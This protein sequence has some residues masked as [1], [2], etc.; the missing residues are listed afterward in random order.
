MGDW[1]TMVLTAASMVVGERAKSPTVSSS[2]A[3]DNT[4][5]TETASRE[6]LTPYVPHTPAGCRMEPPVS[7][8][9][10]KSSQA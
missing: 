2:G 8:P 1:T 7:V 4:P 9:T 3:T 10:V 6:G 5:L